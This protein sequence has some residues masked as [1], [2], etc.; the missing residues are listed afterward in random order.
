MAEFWRMAPLKSSSPMNWSRE[1]I[2]E[3]SLHC[4][5]SETELRTQTHTKTDT[6]TSTTAV[7]KAITT[8][9][10]RVVPKYHTR[11]YG[12]SFS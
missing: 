7:D 6:H 2:L 4:N 5:E 1:A 10:T 11:T 8:A 9:N 12:E 3:R